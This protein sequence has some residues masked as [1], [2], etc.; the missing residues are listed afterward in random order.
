M[1]YTSLAPLLSFDILPVQDN[2]QVIE[3]GDGMADWLVTMVF[4]C[5]ISWIVDSTPLPG[6]VLVPPTVI[7]KVSAGLFTEK[8]TSK[9]HLNP[10]TRDKYGTLV[11]KPKP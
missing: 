2:I 1:E 5:R 4:S 3:Y 11:I 8:L 9:D 6:D 7:T 10:A